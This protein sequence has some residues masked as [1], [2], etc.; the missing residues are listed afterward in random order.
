MK[1]AKLEIKA[2][3]PTAQYANLQ[4]AF[5]VHD[6][7]AQEGTDFLMRHIKDMFERYS[8]KG[9]LKENDLVKTFIQRESFNEGKLVGYHDESHTYECDGVKLVSATEYIKQFYKEFDLENI[10]AASAKSWGV[11]QQEVKDLWE[12]N[13]GLT[14]AFGTVVHNALEH[15]DKFKAMGQIV[16]D[17]K[18]LEENYAM[19]KHPVLKQI[20]EAFIA[21][22]TQEGIIVPEV[23]V[24]DIKNGVCGRADRILIIDEKK[25]ICRVQDF[26][27]NINSEEISSSMKVL[28][29]FSG[30]PAHKI[31]K[32]QLQM[33]IYANMLQ[34]SGWSVE[35]L[36]VFILEDE[37]KHY[38][39]EVLQVIPTGNK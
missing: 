20:I 37:W 4:P 10:S 21:I 15:Y 24:T 14:S 6:V 5:E 30:L 23:L 27:V 32:Y 18:S 25:K 19:P 7:D 34:N 3:I 28:A 12:S 31:S 11:E 2:V 36:D 35:G 13:G 38:K 33:S 16:Q 9:G 1:I 29:P 8:E 22:D 39:L 26:K 17:K